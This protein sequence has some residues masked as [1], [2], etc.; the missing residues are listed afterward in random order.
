M[1][2]KKHQFYPE[3]IKI[4]LNQGWAKNKQYKDWLDETWQRDV[5]RGYTQLGTHQADVSFVLEERKIDT[6]FSR[7]QIKMFTVFLLFSQA[8][9]IEKRTGIKPIILIDDFKAELDKEGSK[10]ILTW[11]TK[12]GYQAFLSTTELRADEQE[13]AQFRRFHVEHGKISIISKG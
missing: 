7:G 4:S 10:R 11:L 12:E 5:E 3:N 8:K 2:E 13:I 9:E 6:V 1:Q